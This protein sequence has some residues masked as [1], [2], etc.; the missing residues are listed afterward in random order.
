MNKYLFTFGQG[1]PLFGRHQIIYASYP[2]TAE[3]KMFEIHGR[4]WAFQYTQENWDMYKSEGFFK[5]NLPL[6]KIYYC[7]EEE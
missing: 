4:E 3:D 6:E 7:E 1:H 2:D 5:Y